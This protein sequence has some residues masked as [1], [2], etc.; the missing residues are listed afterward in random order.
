[1]TD[2]QAVTP[3]SLNDQG[4]WLM[5]PL[6]KLELARMADGDVAHIYTTLAGHTYVDPPEHGQHLKGHS[7]LCL[8]YSRDT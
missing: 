6:A 3:A 1:M 2:V 7:E 4:R 8:L 5:E